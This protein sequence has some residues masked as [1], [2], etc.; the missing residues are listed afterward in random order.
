MSEP[1]DSTAD[2]LRHIA[3]V[4]D[5][6]S[7]CVIAL[8]QRA[9]VHDRSKLSDPEKEAFD[10]CTPVLKTLAYGTEEYTASLRALGP[11]LRH[12]YDENS[13]YPEHY[14]DG[15]TGMDLFDVIEMACDWVAASR[16]MAKADQPPSVN[17]EM[18]V[19]WFAIEPQLAAILERTV[20]RIE[21]F[22]A[23]E[24]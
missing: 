19:K 6:M 14:Q 11:A 16:R 9:A 4:R 23:G 17:M 5:L 8:L 1:Y 22:P 13:Y 18:N 20:R 10:R 7:G 21:T 15:V 24:P 12:H 2:T 3:Q